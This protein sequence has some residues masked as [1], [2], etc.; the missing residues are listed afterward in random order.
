MAADVKG[1]IKRTLLLGVEL[2]PGELLG[3]VAMFSS[4]FLILFTAYLLK[5]A[6]E[7][8]ILTEGTAEIRSYAVALAAARVQSLVGRPCRAMH[9]CWA[10]RPWP[11]TLSASHALRG[12]AAPSA[13]LSCTKRMPS[14]IRSVLTSCVE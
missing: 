5:P 8:L 11:L 6:R 3:V 4:L 7:M 12:A 2:R 1:F 9:R 10:W 13:S 14:W